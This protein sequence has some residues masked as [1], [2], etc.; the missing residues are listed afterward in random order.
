M[1]R[2]AITTMA[3]PKGLI[4]DHN[5]GYRTPQKARFYSLLEGIKNQSSLMV[6]EEDSNQ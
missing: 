4:W 1:H 2:K 5:E 6:P 3:F